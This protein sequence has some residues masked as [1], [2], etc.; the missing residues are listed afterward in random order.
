MMQFYAVI[1][2]VRQVVDPSSGK[3]SFEVGNKQVEP[4]EADDLDAAWADALTRH[5]NA[6]TSDTQVVDIT[7]EE[8][9]LKEP[10]VEQPAEEPEDEESE[11]E[12]A[13]ES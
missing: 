1:E 7:T 5:N 11:A 13:D 9:V 6:L 4:I 8:P 10:V 2:T 12:E 3:L